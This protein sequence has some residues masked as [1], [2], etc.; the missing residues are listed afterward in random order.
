MRA[1]TMALLAPRLGLVLAAA[2]VTA[3][4]L[5][6]VETAN[7]ETLL[8]HQQLARDI[9]KELVDIDTSS[10]TG[11]TARAADAV[12]ARLRAAGFG[13]QDLQVFKPAAR[14]GNVVAR[15]RG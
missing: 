9:F 3:W 11:D 2:I 10:Q 15:L 6:A 5:A 4:P 8:P 14:K 12:A 1:S 13:G 7:A